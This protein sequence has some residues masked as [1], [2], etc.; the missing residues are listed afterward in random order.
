MVPGGGRTGGHQLVKLVRPP[1]GLCE[2]LAWGPSGVAAKT[3]LETQ[4]PGEIQN[5][6]ELVVSGKLPPPGATDPI[7]SGNR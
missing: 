1:S 7:F 2:D 5:L 3:A 4:D 6:G